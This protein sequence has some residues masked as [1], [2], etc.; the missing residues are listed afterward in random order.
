MFGSGENKAWTLEL[1]NA[2]NGSHYTDPEAIQINT[3]KEVIYLG[4][5]ND[6]SFL[7]TDEMNLYE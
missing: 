6:V 4:M 3:I 5:H 7:L 2:V 1:Y